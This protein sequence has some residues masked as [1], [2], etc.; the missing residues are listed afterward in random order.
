VYVSG[1]ESYAFL[2]EVPLGDATLAFARRLLAVLSPVVQPGCR[3]DE[4]VL[5]AR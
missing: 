3:F 5:Y 4:Y 1:H 2:K